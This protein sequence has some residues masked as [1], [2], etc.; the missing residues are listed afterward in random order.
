MLSLRE[1]KKR[2]TRQRILDVALELFQRNG[3]DRTSVDE[4]AARANVSRATCFNY[5]SSKESIVHEIAVRELE[6]L[7]GLAERDRAA[8]PVAK[9][10]NV[11]RRL[12]ADTL[13]YLR[14]TRYVFLG[15][16]LY[17]SNETAFHIRL[18]S[19][20]D[21]LV[22][23]AQALGEIRADLVPTEV[24]QAIIGAYF[25]VVFG[26]IAHSEDTFDA[27]AS[28]ERITDMVFEGIAGP[29]EG[30]AQ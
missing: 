1:R 26:H 25:S 28:V 3:F 17:P 7:Q 11:M 24:V 13:P 22:Q 12:T 10:R 6:Q 30:H 20:L 15:A 2:Q 27:C 29:S 9:I 4:I 16:L 21:R 23:E 5:F 8:S 18:G 19:I 14:I